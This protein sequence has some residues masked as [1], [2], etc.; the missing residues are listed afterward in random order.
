MSWYMYL[1]KKS[2]LK[3]KICV[4][5]YSYGEKMGYGQQTCHLECGI[6][7]DRH[8][9]YLIQQCK[10]VRNLAFGNGHGSPDAVGIFLTLY[11]Y[12]I[13][14][15]LLDTSVIFNKCKIRQLLHVKGKAITLC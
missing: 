9:G 15:P 4:Q 13:I 7:I 14:N 1:G 6:E 10:V 5:K 3:K 2:N 12:E 8:L 11:P